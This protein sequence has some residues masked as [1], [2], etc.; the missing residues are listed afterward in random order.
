MVVDNKSE[1]SIDVLKRNIRNRL[2][3]NGGEYNQSSCINS[4]SDN[5]N[6]TPRWALSSS[7]SKKSSSPKNWVAKSWPNNL[8]AYSSAKKQT[9]DS[10]FQSLKTTGA[11]QQ[12]MIESFIATGATSLA[13]NYSPVTVTE[14]GALQ[15][16]NAAKVP[17]VENALNTTA[18]QGVD[19]QNNNRLINE[20]FE[21]SSKSAKKCK[22]SLAKVGLDVEMVG[23]TR[24]ST[25]RKVGLKSV[26]RVNDAYRTSIVCGT[27]EELIDKVSKVAHNLGNDFVCCDFDNKFLRDGYCDVTLCFRDKSNG[28]VLEVQ[29]NVDHMYEAK[30]KQYKGKQDEKFKDCINDIKTHFEGFLQQYN[31][32]EN[33][34]NSSKK[35]YVMATAKQ[36]AK[37]C[38]NILS[39]ESK[40]KLHDL[41]K[42]Y[43]I[44]D[45]PNFELPESIKAKMNVLQNLMITGYNNSIEK[46]LAENKEDAKYHEILMHMQRLEDFLIH[47]NDSAKNENKAINNVMDYFE[48]TGIDPE[49]ADELVYFTIADGVN[50][51]DLLAVC[52]SR[53]IRDT[54]QQRLQG[55]VG[56]ISSAELRTFFSEGKF[57]AE[58]AKD[59]SIL[60]NNLV[61]VTH[62]DANPAATRQILPSA[63]IKTGFVGTMRAYGAF[64]R[65]GA[66]VG[67]SSGSVQHQQQVSASVVTSPVSMFPT[68][69]SVSAVSAEQKDESLDSATESSSRSR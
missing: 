59:L 31:S 53:E 65:L 36:L 18:S 69:N 4:Y 60:L 41:Y 5:G 16:D 7:K 19:E 44:I 17:A 9:L 55:R 11:K 57:K 52:P 68:N 47:A 10:A 58:D 33:K 25:E 45:D 21:R 64:K 56:A 13:R 37:I 30:S 24:D 1:V 50:I 6:Q 23:K 51:N 40:F 14:I 63:T 48:V 2:N 15:S 8:S 29:F 35:N 49:P 20:I 61:P 27:Y 62:P 38:D 22:N 42:I 54:L 26:D 28:A 67:K 34:D 3:N 46:Y 66:S 43:R 12:R 32:A 39:S